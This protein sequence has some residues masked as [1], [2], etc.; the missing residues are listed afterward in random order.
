MLW[1]KISGKEINIVKVSNEE[2]DEK[3]DKLEF[4][5]FYQIKYK[6]MNID[7]SNR[8]YDVHSN[9][10]EDIIGHP[11]SSLEDDIKE[12]INSS[13]FFKKS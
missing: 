5:K 6:F 9:D 7:Y 3:Y 10:M 8:I 12:V 4:G 1:K 2:I 13:D 11:V